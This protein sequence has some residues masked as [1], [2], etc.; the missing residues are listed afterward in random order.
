MKLSNRYID[1]HLNTI[2]YVEI[3]MACHHYLPD[4]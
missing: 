3:R 1:Y 2:A 4:N